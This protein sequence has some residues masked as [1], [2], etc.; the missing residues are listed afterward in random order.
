MSLAS[1]PL[2]P[3]APFPTQTPHP[4]YSAFRRPVATRLQELLGSAVTFVPSC[5]GEVAEAACAEP[6]AGSVILLENL[7]FHAEE[8][9]KG[10]D[11]DGNKVTPTE[12]CG[13][14]GRA[15]ARANAGRWRRRRWRRSGPR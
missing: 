5:V 7:R 4:A 2:P 3:L 15:R 14:A 11:A 6:A 13:V 8:E 12:V 10:K 1:V 9:G